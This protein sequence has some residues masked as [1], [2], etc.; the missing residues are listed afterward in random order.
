MINY[1]ASFFIFIIFTLSFIVTT[2]AQTFTEWQDQNVNELNRLPMRSSF[3]PFSSQ[4]VAG[5]G[6]PNLDANY[7]DLNGIWNFSWV[8][9]ADERPLDFFK[10]DFDDRSWGKMPVPGLWE[11]NGYGDPLYVNIGYAWRNDFKNNP[12]YVPVEKNHVGSYRKKITIPEEW[13]DKEILAHFGSVTSNIYFWVNGE[14][15]G[16]SEDSKLEPEFNITP[17]VKPG[18]ENTLAFQVFRWNDGTYLEDQD[19][20]RLSGVARDSYLYARSKDVQLEDIRVTPDL[21]NDYTDGVLNIDFKVKGDAK[22]N[23]ELKDP[24]GR[25]IERT[26]TSGSGEKNININVPAPK[27]WTAE[28]PHLY[29]ITATLEKNGKIEEVIPI[30][31][32]FRKVEIKNGQLIINGRPIIIKGVNRHEMDPDG[33]YV[34][35]RE[36]MLEDL[37]IM[38]ENNINAVRTSHYPNDK[39]WYDLCDSV[40]IYVV[41]EAN[42]ESHG[43]GYGSETL[44]KRK[45]WLLPH[46]QR[47]QR[48]V[49][50]NFNHPSVIIWSMGNEAGNGDNFREVYDWI[51]NEDPSRPVQYEQ[52]I[53]TE[54]TDIICPMYAS[55]DWV[56]TY[57]ENIDNH[58]P[59]IQCEYN[60][61]MGNSGGGFKE[62]MDLTR[63]YPINQGGFIWDFV[64]Q[65]LRGTGTNGKIIYK[66][67]GDYNPYDASDNNFCDNGLL[68]PDRQPHPHMA[69]VK[70]QYQNIWVY[71]VNL[72]KGV[73]NIYNE[74]VFTDLSNY[75]LKWTLLRNGKA[76]QT[77]IVDTLNIPSLSETEIALPY[78]LPSG[79]E[80][81]LLN[82]E[83]YTKEEKNLVSSGHL[84]AN[85]QFE[86][87]GYNFHKDE[88]KR[89]S[90]LQESNI[91][92]NNSQRLIISNSKFTIEFDKKTGYVNKYE[93]GALSMLETGMEITPSFWRA[94]TDNEYGN[95]FVERSK[96]WRNPDLKLQEMKC[97]EKAGLIY[98]SNT[99]IIPQLGCQYKMDYEI[100]SEG[101]I[102]LTAILSDNSS[103]DIP[104]MNRYGIRIPMPSQMD[105][106]SYY[107]RG[108]IENYNDRKSSAFLGEYSQHA[109]DQAHPYIRPQETGTKSDM[110]Y[111][112]QTNIGGKGLKITSPSPFYASATNYT[113][114]SL[115]NGE[116]KTQR[117]FN[118]VEPVEY[119]NLMIDSEQNGVGGINSWGAEPLEKYRMKVGEKKLSLILTPTELLR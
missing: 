47:N 103:K 101:Q 15:V 109:K 61:V 54:W 40:G 114:E 76:I 97:I 75:F 22:V 14:F 92:D 60:H 85:N 33:G 20:W 59:F 64:D 86:I 77:G 66:Y 49:A 51:K 38:K 3:Y 44:A 80:E 27:K 43:M 29:T 6:I 94:P 48:N 91:N 74:N 119:V 99:Y 25:V 96:I 93:V 8:E 115:D 2:E 118:E 95:G 87:R 45:D 58:R 23:F 71:P 55:P 83:F 50:R 35:S 34:V 17:F 9:N 65:G 102:M 72:E 5:V 110:R 7:L 70:H 62:Y 69:E 19:F 12:P 116:E 81:L 68:N 32:G 39:M 13:K 42:L 67:G 31:V 104:E 88:F 24:E 111:W 21:I 82:L 28:T 117:H 53:Q 46:M 4:K 1:R 90:N 26:F 63:E 18:E 52:A 112:I 73:I 84:S 108:P 100:N 57:S 56:K 105:I 30:K 11:L 78:S 37:R 106:S 107:G 36:R 98:V 113:V 79:E 10:I 41:A 89:N 16:Y